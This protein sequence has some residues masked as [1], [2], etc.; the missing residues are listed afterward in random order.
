MN[1]MFYGTSFT[2]RDLSDWNV[3]NV[4]EHDGFFEETGTAN[5]EP[6]WR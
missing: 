2:N 6:N 3:S 4:T 1:F 5:I